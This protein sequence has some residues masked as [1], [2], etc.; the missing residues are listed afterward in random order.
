MFF[1]YSLI[2]F[3][4]SLLRTVKDPL[5]ITAPDSG[6]IALPFLKIWFILPMAFAGTFLFTRLSNRYSREKVFYIMIS[7]FLVFFVVFAFVL[8]PFRDVLHPTALGNSLRAH[9]PKGLW[10]MIAVFQNWSFSLFYVMAELWGAIVMTVLFWAFAN[11]VTSVKDARRFYGIY[12]LGA[13]IAT[14]LVGILPGYWLSSTMYKK[15]ASYSHD[16]WGAKLMFISIVIAIVGVIVIGLYH[17]LT[18]HIFRKEIVESRP[19]DETHSKKEKM[20]LRT[21][22]AYLMKSKYLIYIAIL[23][24]GFNISLTMIEVIWKDQIH[25]LFP[26]PTDFSNYN[27]QVA[28]YIGLTATVFSLFFCRQ[29]IRRFGWSAGAYFTPIIIGVTGLL[30]FFFLLFEHTN[31]VL[32]VATFLGTTPLAIAVFWGTLNNT[33]SRASKFTFF[34]VTKEMAFIPLPAEAKLKGKAAIDG[35]GSRLGKTGGSVIHNVLLVS[36]STLAFSAPFIAL[37]LCG[38]VAAWI[39]AVRALGKQ[40]RELSEDEGTPSAPAAPLKEKVSTV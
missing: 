3:V 19:F 39:A 26:N 7:I 1:I 33:F 27:E 24:L 36:F 29:T 4:Y 18:H 32:T 10:G 12:G 23:V 25:K 35:I 38:V 31:L 30:F 9:S 14:T 34:D 22:F 15:L 20:S 13:N 16:D 17:W 2:A 21:N 37:I 11:E 40:F 8:Y 28:L 5:V 6:A